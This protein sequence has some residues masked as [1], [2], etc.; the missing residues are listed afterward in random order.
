[1]SILGDLP[2]PS[3]RVLT[4]AGGAYAA[5]F[6]GVHL[7]LATAPDGLTPAD[8]VELLL[9]SAPAAALAAPRTIRA[10]GAIGCVLALVTAAAIGVWTLPASALTPDY[11]SWSLGAV[12]FVALGLAFRGRQL[13][14]WVTLV[15]TA[16]IAIGW[17]IHMGLGPLVGVGLVVRHFATLL[18]GSLLGLALARSARSAAEYEAAEGRERA[19]AEA[20]RARKAARQAAARA[21][22]D[23]A[24]PLLEQLAAG[25][26]LSDRDRVELL[27][28]EGALRDRIRAPALLRGHLPSRVA[29]ARRRGMDV[30][31]LDEAGDLLDDAARARAAAW[32]AE[33]LS[34]AQ[35]RRFVGRLGVR[36][37]LP[38]V[39]A[40]TNEGSASLELEAEPAVPT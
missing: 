1:M 37:G 3:R 32:L 15:C 14:A 18:A 13:E 28:V 39:T 4:I 11:R 9:V 31:L 29:A 38:R 30:L 16:G 7:V 33:R 26:P 6:I 21:V 24:G 17:S 40:V 20:A 8:L 10:P 23:Q 35:G 12:T 5:L 2:G 22:L 25:R 34:E 36:D 19:V 27:V